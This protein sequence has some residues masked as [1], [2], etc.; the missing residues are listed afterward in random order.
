MCAAHLCF[1]YYSWLDSSPTQL[2]SSECLCTMICPLPLLPPLP[3][4]S[5]PPLFKNLPSNTTYYDPTPPSVLHWTKV[6]VFDNSSSSSINSVQVANTLPNNTNLLDCPFI[7]LLCYLPKTK[8]T[9]QYVLA[10]HFPML[11]R[12]EKPLQFHIQQLLD[13]F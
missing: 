1:V 11:T 13:E 5:P 4:Y 12:E 2:L 9:K 8:P 3:P 10:P 7:S 6:L